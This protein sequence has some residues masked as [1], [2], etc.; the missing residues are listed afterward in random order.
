[1]LKL[2]LIYDRRSAG[3]SV[4]VLGSQLEP[5]TRFLF[6]LWRLRFLNVGHPLWRE[7]G[8]LIYPYSCFCALPEQSLLGPS[9]AELTTIFYS[10]LRFPKPIGSDPCIY[11]PQERG[12]PVIP[13]G[14]GIW[15][16]IGEWL[17]ISTFSWPR[18]WL[19]MSGELY[20]PAA[21][22]PGK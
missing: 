16:R 4:F 6:S 14:T 15:R 10:H 17:Y 8:S 9:P 18:H 3:Q 21:L 7:D 19:E 1:M 22:P 11:I 5:K 2:K 20:A 13:L 12:G